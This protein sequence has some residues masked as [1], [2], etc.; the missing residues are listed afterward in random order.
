MASN[1]DNIMVGSKMGITKILAD[2]VSWLFSVGGPYINIHV[3]GKNVAIAKA[4]CQI[5]KYSSYSYQ[6]T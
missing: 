1:I 2:F 3:A 4:D 5:A 6:W